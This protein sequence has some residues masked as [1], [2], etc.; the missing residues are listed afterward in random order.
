MNS[1]HM[2][3]FF[4]FVYSFLGWICETIYCSFANKKFVY[5]GFLNG[6]IC[7]IYGFGALLVIFC[8]EKYSYNIAIIFILGLLLTSTIEYL[9]SFI[10]EKC[11]KISLWDYSNKKYNLNSRICLKNSTIFG[12]MSVFL[13]EF[14]QPL[15]L[16]IISNFNIVTLD[17]ISNLL[18]LLFLMDF[19]ITLVALVGV[20]N[21]IKKYE[22]LLHEIIS[23][24]FHFKVLHD[25]EILDKEKHDLNILI[26]KLDNHYKKGHPIENKIIFKEKLSSIKNNA[27]SIKKQY[28]ILHRF[29]NAFPNMRW[30]N[31]DVHFQNLKHFFKNK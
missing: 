29:F 21:K 24:N 20:S 1:S 11:F 3:L 16:N 9:T 26:N 28:F 10:L 7:P 31:K 19:S 23:F 12:V 13:I 27:E 4:F 17:F 5:R 18:L 14:L 6:P 22:L 15:L 30:L 25:S 2:Y 8:L